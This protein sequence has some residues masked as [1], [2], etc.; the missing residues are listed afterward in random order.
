MTYPYWD[1]QTPSEYLALESKYNNSL[2]DLGRNS[3]TF[4]ETSF[5]PIQQKK[6]LSCM[7]FDQV[8]NNVLQDKTIRCLNTWLEIVLF[9][10]KCK[11]KLYILWII[12][13]LHTIYNV[14][15]KKRQT[16]TKLR[17]NKS[18]LKHEITKRNWLVS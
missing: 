1:K 7:W 4:L 18:K 16:M 11:N 6:T 9:Y 8:P 12:D 13:V 5:D 14:N 2:L 15:L 17:E 10:C 3:H